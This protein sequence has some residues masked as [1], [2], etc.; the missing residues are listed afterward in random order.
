[1]DRIARGRLVSV[2]ISSYVM[3]LFTAPPAVNICAN[4]ISL[5]HLTPVKQLI[6][7]DKNIAFHTAA[8]WSVAAFTVISLPICAISN[9]L[10][11][12]TGPRQ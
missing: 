12:P 9:Y 10:L 11:L 5:L 3:Q 8:S 7:F 2:F 4:F 1:M 6:I